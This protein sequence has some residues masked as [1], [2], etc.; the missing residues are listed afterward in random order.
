[1]LPP[2][3]RSPSFNGMTVVILVGWLLLNIGFVVFLS[4]GPPPEAKSTIIQTES[5]DGADRAWL[6]GVV[7]GLAASFSWLATS[8]PNPFARFLARL[9]AAVPCVLVLAF[10]GTPDLLRHAVNINGLI[11]IQLFVFLV[12]GIPN[13]SVSGQSQVEASESHQRNQFHIGELIALTAVVAMLLAAGERYTTPINSL[14]YW[15]VLVLCWFLLQTVAAMTI[16]I[17]MYRRLVALLLLLPLICL[18]AMGL[19][20]AENF[21]RVSQLASGVYFRVYALLLGGF[22]TSI[23]ITSLAGA[24]TQGNTT[25]DNPI[26]G[27]DAEPG[28]NE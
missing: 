21:F 1:M 12:A 27:F 14:A 16:R 2:T 5:L 18:T 6:A 10:F 25:S 3:Y 22:A 23:A 26:T 17:A 9:L 15:P 24:P 20:A 4:S 8:L 19:T 7:L 28:K 11:L 13:W